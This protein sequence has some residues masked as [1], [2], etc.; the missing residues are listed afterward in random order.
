M[1]CAAIISCYNQHETVARCLRAFERQTRRPDG[2]V[3]ADD[4]SRRTPGLGGFVP[5]GLSVVHVWQPDEGNRKP[6]ALNRAVAHAD[7]DALVFVDADCLPHRRFVEDHM[8]LL[9]KFPGR[10]IQGSRA[11]VLEPF[12][13]GFD[14]G[15]RT[16]LGYI[17]R[18]KI[19]SR[20]KAIRFPGI[21][22]RFVWGGPFYP[23]GSNI[24]C[25]KSDYVAINGYDEEFSGS[26]NEDRDFC[27][28]LQAAGIAPVEASGCCILF[29]LGHQSRGYSA[30][31]S[32][33]IEDKLR[34]GRLEPALG[35]AGTCDRPPQPVVEI[36]TGPSPAGAAARRRPSVR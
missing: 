7:A 36:L 12:A 31:N 34:T 19:T 16:T 32:R 4:G 30:E 3:I 28:R 18:G 9:A 24:S 1:T 35:F 29:H 10:Y 6:A 25:R 26:Y 13:P 17:L 14:P 27:Y 33:R 2:I 21:L 15:F 11:E 22:R 8:R 20:I 5:R 23:C